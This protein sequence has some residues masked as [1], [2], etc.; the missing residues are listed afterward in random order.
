MNKSIERYYGLDI[1]KVIA[2][3]MVLILH[4]L[5]AS[6]TLNHSIDNQNYYL[7]HF[8]DISAYCAV[9][10]FAII[11]GFCGVTQAVNLSN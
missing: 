9:D 8:I 1:L 2:M 7:A 3:F 5:N 6:E 10:I 4:I 11:T